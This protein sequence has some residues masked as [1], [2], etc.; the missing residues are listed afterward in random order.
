ME[1]SSFLGSFIRYKENEVLWIRPQVLYP[2][3]FIALKANI[4]WRIKMLSPQVNVTI[5]FYITLPLKKWYKIISILSYNINI[6]DN[7]V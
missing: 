2:Q 5:H 7:N 1:H 3:H 6:M 4:I